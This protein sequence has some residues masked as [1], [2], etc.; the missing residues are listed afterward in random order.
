VFL[1]VVTIMRRKRAV[2]VHEEMELSGAMANVPGIRLQTCVSQRRNQNPYHKKEP[3]RIAIRISCGGNHCAN[4]CRADE[5][6]DW[7]KNAIV[8]NDSD[9]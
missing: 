2:N 6:V 8:I 4:S 1:S 9:P 3:K 5:L 7:T